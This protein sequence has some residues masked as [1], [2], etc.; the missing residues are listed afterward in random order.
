MS[1]YSL[2]RSST[3]DSLAGHTPDRLSRI[4]PLDTSYR[5]S[6]VFSWIHRGAASFDEMTNIP[7]TLRTTLAGTGIPMYS[8][9]VTGTQA[10][11]QDGSVKFTLELSDGAVIESVLLSD[12]KGRKTA[13]LSSQ[14][15][16]AMGCT[17]CRTAAMGLKRSLSPSEIAE[18]FM[19]I[20]KMAADTSHIVFMG[21]G[22][23]LANLESVK[24]AVEVFHHPESYAMSHRRMTISTCGIPSG[25]RSLARE[26]P[27]VRLAL[28]LITA[29]EPLRESLMPAAGKFPLKEIKEALADHQARHRQRITLEYVLLK[30]IND[31]PEDIKALARF[32]S[33]LQVL[34]N[35]I[36]WNPAAELPFTEPAKNDT[37]AFAKRIMNAGLNC[38][39]R[40]GKGRGINGACGQLAAQSAR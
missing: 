14:A 27:P 28:S 38:V 24:Q 1:H 13:C 20:R 35:L 12:G 21:M 9:R 19:H 10:D 7:K 30:G 8:S 5:S 34:V 16:C 40:Y 3:T 32:A 36:P 4:L 37:A 31:T 18:Q 17:F 25:I 26:G 33:G 23:P 22:E 15:G 11:P 29:R 2:R 6:Q 39:T